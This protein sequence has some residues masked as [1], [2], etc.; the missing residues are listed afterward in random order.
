[1]PPLD[2]SKYA[3][4]PNDATGDSVQR[5]AEIVNRARELEW[6]CNAL[7][8]ERGRLRSQLSAVRM[9]LTAARRGD[10]ALVGELR[11]AL[12]V[13]TAEASTLRADLATQVGLVSSLEN[14]KSA[15]R[16]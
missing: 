9:E 7:E 16:I 11:E 10:S 4:A 12:A 3:S 6:A 15:P 13:A 5:E 2:A 14:W 8:D 1:M